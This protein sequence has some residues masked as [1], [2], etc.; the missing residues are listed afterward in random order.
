[1]TR[2]LAERRL[3]RRLVELELRRLRTE[4][5]RVA[6]NRPDYVRSWITA[7]HRDAP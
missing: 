6:W 1:M 2:D 5:S 3:H 7:E 4:S